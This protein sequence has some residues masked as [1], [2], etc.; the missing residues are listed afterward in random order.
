MRA[1]RRSTF[2][3]A[4]IAVAVL[5]S[6]VGGGG[7][8]ADPRSGGGLRYG[9]APDPDRGTTFQPDVVLVEGGADAVR[10]V[11]ADGLTWTL[12]PDARGIADLAP[13]RVLFLTDR[14]VGRVAAVQT[15]QAGVEVTIGPVDIAEV[16]ADGEFAAEAVEL[17]DPIVLS[18]AGAFWADPDLQ[19]EAGLE[20]GS[21]GDVPVTPAVVLTPRGGADVPRPPAPAAIV[22]ETAKATTGNFALTGGCCSRGAGVDLA[23]DKNGLTMSG[24]V[25][26]DMTSPKAAFTLKIAG[27]SVTEAGLRVSGAAGIRANLHAV[28]APG[29]AIKGFSPPLGL[30]FAFSVPVGEFFGVPLS[31]VVTQRFT[32][33]ITIPGTA[34][35]DAVG[36]VDLG[37]TI[38]FAYRNGS[39]SN[40]TSAKLDSAASLR[41]TNSVAVGLSYAAF[42]Y[43]IRFTVGLGYL[44]F[45]A[46]VF[47]EIAAHILA[48]VGPPLGFNPLPDAE[49]PIE[50]CKSI[51]SDVFVD[52]GVGYTIPSAVA[53][54]VNF[55]MAA[56][57]AA[58]IPTHGGLSHGFEPVLTKYE[59]FPQS[60]FCR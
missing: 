23:Y 3:G 2:L 58:P 12:S 54:L 4:V 47:L 6:C 30:D 41:G 7:A 50:A 60:G 20:P 24:R 25:A 34:V 27:G 8:A 13:G 28:A 56:F 59:V 40:L 48:A 51:Q 53:K 43:T 15:T 57:Q 9:L 44:G 37:A 46:G 35:L 21:G 1:R 11:T 39:F 36:K 5:T 18:A 38:G 10:A 31:M 32:V 49:A 14:G 17:A 19:Q 52:Y 16:I 22:A 42:D 45:V 33:T 26:V 29:S 55:F